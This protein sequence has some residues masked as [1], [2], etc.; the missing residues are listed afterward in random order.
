MMV[1]SSDMLGN[2]CVEWIFLE[3]PSTSGSSSSEAPDDRVRRK[4]SLHVGH[5]NDTDTDSDEETLG[6]LNWL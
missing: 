6:L 1:I 5:Y 2:M 4:V 3:A